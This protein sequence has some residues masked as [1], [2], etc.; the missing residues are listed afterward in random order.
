MAPP[1]PV[2]I[3]SAPSPIRPTLTAE[4]AVLLDPQASA[5]CDG[6]AISPA[7]SEDLPPLVSG[8]AFTTPEIGQ[9]IVTAMLAFSV[10]VDGRT[11]N[12]RQ[13]PL[14]D[15]GSESLFNPAASARYQSAL[16]AWR[17]DGGARSACW[18]TIRFT[19]V[20]VA[21]A[22]HDLL[23]RYY[24]V[25][26]TTGVVRDA[27]EARLR[28]PDADCRRRRPRLASYPDHRIGAPLPPA[29]YGWSVVQWNVD[30]EGRYDAVATV[31]SSG[32]AAYDA[33]TRRAM[34]ENLAW[35]GAASVG[36]VYN[37]YRR[38]EPLPAPPLPPVKDDSLANCPAS[39]RDRFTAFR[40]PVYPNDFRQ[41][42]VEGWALVRFDI[43]SWGAIGNVE[44]VEAQPAAA[45]ADSAL[46]AVR[47]GRV[48]PGFDAGIRC[49]VPVRFVM[50]PP[51]D[52]APV[53]D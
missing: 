51:R 49:V 3:P 8:Q 48:T 18:L 52:G 36:C 12:I 47:L 5:T 31:G 41:R 7:Y 37:F 21:R 38:G 17:F 27:V 6:Q 20:P 26:R 50:E 29:G 46:T 44:I 24:A 43:A 14:P 30:A 35:E 53:A 39:V 19:P 11:L 45:F 28:G 42:G 25:T 32:D 34:S 33:E 4:N 15:A 22:D 40:D 16:A 10:G 23:L 2:I 1:P 9:R 13:Q